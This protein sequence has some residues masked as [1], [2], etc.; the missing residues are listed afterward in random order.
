MMR[1]SLV[2]ASLLVLACSA[3]ALAG[4]PDPSRSTSSMSTPGIGPCHYVLNAPGNQDAMTVRVTLRDAFDTPVAS[5]ATDATLEFVDDGGDPNDSVCA[6]GDGLVVSGSTDANGIVNLTWTSLGG[7]GVINI[8]ITARCQGNIAI[9][10]FNGLKFT[11]PD[12]D[13]SCEASPSSSTGVIDLGI[14]ASGLP[15]NYFEPADY[16]CTG[17]VGVIDLGVFASGLGNGC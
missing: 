15:P 1:K 11:S 7:Y 8:H 2:I 9:N 5:C 6:C 4:V 10:S 14:F 17:N 13:G 3:A 16:D 12:L